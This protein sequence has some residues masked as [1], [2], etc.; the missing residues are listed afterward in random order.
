MAN[1]LASHDHSVLAVRGS[2]TEA[3]TLN[4]S[5]SMKLRSTFN[6]GKQYSN[7]SYEYSHGFVVNCG[8]NYVVLI[9][10]RDA[11]EHNNRK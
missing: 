2:L 9:S 1:S 7:K 11:T 5:S 4:L 6:S 10:N 8:Q 3:V